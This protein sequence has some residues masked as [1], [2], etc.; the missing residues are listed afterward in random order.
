M[1]SAPTLHT[2]WARAV[3]AVHLYRSLTLHRSEG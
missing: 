3:P 2:Q 1:Q